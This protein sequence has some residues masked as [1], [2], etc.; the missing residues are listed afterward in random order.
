MTVNENA[1]RN[2][3][4]VRTH[5]KRA[6]STITLM[7]VIG[8]LTVFVETMLVPALPTIS[9]EL[10]ASS[11]D[12]A[13]V[14]TGY[15]LAGAVTIP[16]VGKMGE[17]WG[18]KRVLLS[19]MLVYML[20]LA[21]AAVSWDLLSLIIFR[22][23]Q[24]IGMSAV[25]LLMGMAMDMLPSRMVPVGIGLISAMIGVGA[26]TGL[27]VGGVLVALLGWKECF[28]VVL[29]VVALPLIIVNRFIPDVQLR[30][31]ARM[32]AF[33]AGLLGMAVLSLLLALSQG[34][35]W[36]WTSAPTIGLLA[37]AAV[38]FAAF[39]TQ[40]RRCQE[41]MIRLELLRNRNIS[42]AYINM[43]F[44]GMVMFML[45]QTLPYFLG[46]PTETGGFGIS[47]QVVI[48]LF[49][50]PNAAA[51]LVSS[52]LSGRLG[53]RIGHWQ[54]LVIGLVITSA[55][56]VGMALL[57]SSQAAIL[58]TVMI[59]GTGIGMAGVGNTNLL[60][61]VCSKEVF[62]TATSVNSMILTIGMSVGPVAASMIM[63]GVAS[64]G[65]SYANC[66][67][68]AALLALMTVAFTLINRA[69]LTSGIIGVELQE[70]RLPEG[71]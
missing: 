45:Y 19:I 6:L 20:G 54:V 46:M 8:L 44:I 55:G 25:P 68:M 36:G 2:I 10:K 1:G 32:D 43:F 13:W 26:A 30:R 4:D 7:A 17:M 16:I 5:E 12:L 14:L 65:S 53:Q 62:G 37:A 40:E 29:P 3:P 60:S 41:P 9:E 70:A 59:F 33:G 51:Q 11:S 23:V 42:V 71:D 69:R 66:W 57:S 38:L 31:P 18:R 58:I 56:L 47:N 61:C 24:G 15:T 22:A 21:G 64:G 67:I 28:W 35:M 39:V 50:L 27:V 34:E 49:L 63:G 48:G 52:P